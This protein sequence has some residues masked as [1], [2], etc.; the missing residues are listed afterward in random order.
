MLRRLLNFFRPDHL[1]ADM[2]EE[3]DYHQSRTS[4]SFG[5]A[6]LIR[7][8]MRDASTISWLETTWQ[9][10][11]YGVRMMRRTPG[12]SS[13]AILSLAL[14]IG[15]NAAIF[16]LVDHLLV[17]ALPV[18]RPQQLVLFNEPEAY[19][20]YQAFRSGTSVFSDI[21]GIANLTG[22]S[23]NGGE[24]PED[25]L[26]GRLVSGNYFR[27]LGVQPILGRTLSESEDADPGAHPVVVISY[28]LWRDRFHS[29]PDILGK[30]I[31][32]G[33]GRLSSDW[34]SSGFEESQRVREYNGSF[35][36]LGVMPPGFF[37]ETVGER[38]DFW[39]PLT[40]EEYFLPGRHW[41]TRRTVRWVLLIGRLKSGVALQQA[42]AATNLL[43][44]HVL[45]EAEGVQSTP[46]RR[47]EIEAN[48]I[49]LLEGTK[50]FSDLRQQFAKPLWAL[51]AMVAVV[52]L[53]ACANLANLL[54][55]KGA[56]RWREIGTRLAL[57]VSRGRLIRQL[58]TESFLL[59]LSGAILSI[60]VGWL[61][62][63]ALFAMVS[64]GNAALK[65][66][67]TP[68]IQVLLF[69]AAVAILTT[70]FFG[71]VPAFRSTRVDLQSVL[72]DAGRAT[73]GNRSRLTGE[74]AVVVLQVALSTTLLF[75]TILFTRTLYNLRAQDLGY[76]PE[77]LLT[78]RIDPIGAG[79]KG[80]EVGQIAQRLLEKL[81][82]TPGISRA[83][84]SDNGLF[85]G[86]DS[87]SR[88]RV[89][90]FTPS[91]K[92]DSMA[93]FDQVG[94]DYFS[95]VEI[96]ILLGR[97]FKDSDNAGSPRVTVINQSLA[98]F[99]F[100][101]RNPIGATIFYDDDLKF[102]LTVIGVTRD[103]KEY[104]REQTYRRFYVP[105][106]QPV[107]GQMDAE[108]EIRS[109]LSAAVLDRRIR[110]A[111][112]SVSPRLNVEYVHSVR[113]SID[114]SIIGERL[115]ARL[116]IVFGLLALLL[117]CVG[118]YGVMSYSVVRRTREIGIRMAIGGRPAKIVFAVLAD[119]LL[120]AALGLV[121]GIPIA[122]LLGRFLQSLLFGLEAADVWSISLVIVVMA[123][124]A[125]IA[126][127]VPAHRATRI[128]AVVALRAE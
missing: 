93:R 44:H 33:T 84:Y 117:G 86:L 56:A 88:I 53:I 29:D 20:K 102:A 43:N 40:M 11:R 19:W 54:L 59:S 38:P 113:T 55:A 83:S 7:D 58:I 119:T 71:V 74:K 112:R 121:L 2:Q 107:D 103:V 82:A 60:P 24:N 95:T 110:Q 15:A 105:Y 125:L 100:R 75:G 87:G 85:T 14:G 36:I 1:E 41:L 51:L 76:S 123:S 17:D 128:N 101:K 34:G 27:L 61:A 122:I 8:R 31:R 25:V 126:S 35:T 67:L 22:V 109:Q 5:N 3:L 72:K 68:D 57:G 63:R 12:V 115:V 64:A 111:V 114:D 77:S 120:V 108:F 10:L 92:K 70:F 52:L 46:N 48:K 6:L 4:G 106:M 80:V 45:Q 89:D 23:F 47:L 118:L 18:K 62:S 21:A 127:V 81:R 39:A 79:Y 26:T 73:Q 37:G 32:L 13:I 42:E 69:T 99:Y 30:S 91:S 104:M 66:D 90:G 96:P 16:S 65:I 9:D 94:P 97:E 28:F 116:S 50:G 49:K 98:N 124:V 78:A